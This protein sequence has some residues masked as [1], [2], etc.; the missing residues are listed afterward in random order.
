MYFKICSNARG[1]TA[2]ETNRLYE[3]KNTGNNRCYR[4]PC[5]IT[6]RNILDAFLFSDPLFTSS[7]QEYTLTILSSGAS[8]KNVGNI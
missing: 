1:E 6:S 8:N 5:M 2:T 7:D 3:D 4:C